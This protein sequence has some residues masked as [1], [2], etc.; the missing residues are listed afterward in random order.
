MTITSQ[1]LGQIAIYLKDPKLTLFTGL[2]NDTMDM[3]NIS[4]PSEQVEF[5]AQVLHESG[6]CRYLTELA[7]G[8]AY[9]GRK[10]LGNTSPGDGVKY[11]GRGL[12]QITGKN[13]YQ[14]VSDYFNHDFIN[15]P[16]D[17]ADPEWAT[18]S[19]GWFWNLRKLNQF[20]DDGSEAAF[21]TETKRINGG[22]NGLT[23]REQLWSKAKKVL[24]V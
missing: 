1:Q 15:N 11:K 3:F 24:G 9:E 20:A 14:L 5:L 18:K 23:D 13:N 22:T 12:I 21:I 19:A 16:E 17:L 6:E 2:L 8:E 4:T 7:S 10:D